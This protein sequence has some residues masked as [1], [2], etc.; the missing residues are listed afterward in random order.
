MCCS[1]D[2]R[3]QRDRPRDRE[4]WVDV[5]MNKV[6]CS[7]SLGPYIA[8]LCLPGGVQDRG[9]AIDGLRGRAGTGERADARS[10]LGDNTGAVMS[11]QKNMI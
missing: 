8:C 10:E 6:G 1:V 7:V 2:T 4:R 9:P 3:R 5:H 11:R